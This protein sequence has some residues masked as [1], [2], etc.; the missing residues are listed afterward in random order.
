MSADETTP[1]GPLV[2]G[3]LS[4]TPEHYCCMSAIPSLRW[5]RRR[6]YAPETYSYYDV[7]QFADQC[8]VCGKVV[9]NDVPTVTEEEPKP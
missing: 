2:A 5:V 6:R 9:W 4:A 1:T 7:L 3:T 8:R